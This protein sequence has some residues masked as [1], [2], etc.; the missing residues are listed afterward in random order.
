MYRT[1]RISILNSSKPFTLYEVGETSCKVD[2]TF[3][4]GP[5]KG[6]LGVVKVCVFVIRLKIVDLDPLRLL[7]TSFGTGGR[8]RRERSKTF[9]SV[10]RR[11]AR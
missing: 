7:G 5:R 10:S 11:G 3:P 6:Q 4:R 8:E 2:G 1:L 9:R